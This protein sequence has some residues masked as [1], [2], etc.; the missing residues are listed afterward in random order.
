MKAH[1]VLVIGA[2]EEKNQGNEKVTFGYR[3]GGGKGANHMDIWE[4]NIPNGGN[5]KCKALRLDCG[6]FQEQQ[7]GQC[8]RVG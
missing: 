1:T 2:K 8:V 7:G 5:S 4:K 3:P 6:L